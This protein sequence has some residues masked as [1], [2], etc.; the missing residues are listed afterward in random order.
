MSIKEEQIL[1]GSDDKTLG[2]RRIHNTWSSFELN[3]H[4][5]SVLSLDFDNNNRFLVSGG[6]DS[7]ILLWDYESRTVI[8]KTKAH[9]GYVQ[10]VKFFDSF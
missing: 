10:V 2:L 4:Q 1:S 8:N 6:K 3:G 5:R 7:L 9:E